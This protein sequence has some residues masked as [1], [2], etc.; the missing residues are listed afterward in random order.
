MRGEYRQVI[1]EMEETERAEQTRNK[2]E[3]GDD[4]EEKRERWMDGWMPGLFYNMYGK[5]LGTGES[6]GINASFIH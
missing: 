4:N 1:K 5:C 6:R 2:G 3:R